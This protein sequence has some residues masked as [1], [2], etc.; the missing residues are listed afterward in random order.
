VLSY[1]SANTYA[2]Q[3][4]V[5][6]QVSNLVASAPAT[7]D[8]LNELAAAL[9]N[10]PSF[11]TTI[12]TALGNRLRVD[13][14]TQGLSATLQGYGRTNLGLGTAATSNTGDFVAYRTFGTAANSATG[15]FVAYRTFGTAANNNTEDFALASH[16]H[17]I[18]NVTGLQT[19]LDGKQASGSY[20]ASSHSHIISDVTGLQT[21]LDGK[22]AS[23]SGTG[24]VKISGTTISYDN[25]TYLTGI[26]SGQV[27]TALG[28][29]PYNSTN[30]A[31]YITGVTN[32]S[33]TAGSTSILTASGALTT[34]Q[35]SGTIIYS[36]ALTNPQ[37]GLFS[38]S[39]NSNSILTFNRHSGD[40]YSQLGFNSSGGIFYRSF[41]ATAIN[42]SQAW[43]TIWTSTSLT[44]LN[45]LTNGPGYI[46]GVTNISGTAGSISGFNNPT[47]A[48]TANTI[49]YRDSSGDLYARYFL[50]G[51][52]NTSDNVETGTI[53][54]IMAKFGD[55]YHRSATAAK[56]QAF[57]GLGSLA[58]S[59][60]T[61][62]TNN[63]QLTNGAGYI[64]GISSGNVT[65]ALGYTPYNN[66]N[67]SGYIGIN[68]QTYFGINNTSNSTG[69]G[70][71]LYGAYGGG[72]M[73]YGIMFAGTP[74]FGTHG[75]VTGDWATYFTMNADNARGWI[76]RKAG[77]A[78]VASISGGGNA[79]FTG[80]VSASNLSGT[81]TGDQTNIS[82]NAATATSAGTVTGSSTIGGYLTLSTNWGVSPYTSAFTII[83]THPSMTFR[84]SNADTHY[85]IHMD[86]AGD[87]QYYFGPGY[88]S[89]NWT[90]R[91]T[92]TKG[93]N[94]SALTGNISAS[95]TISA[96]NFSGSHSG[97]SSGTNTGDQTNISGNAAT[98]TTAT[99]SS[100]L[101]GLS[102]AQLWNNSGQNHSTYQ[103]FAAIPNFGVW[104]MQN[105]S[106]GDSPQGSSQYYVQTQGLGNDY[107]YGTYGLMTA[108]ARD[109]A[110][111]YTYYRTQ[112]GTTWGGWTKAAAGYADSAG[113]AGS[114]TYATNS[115]RLYASDGGYVYGGAAPYYMYMTYDGTRWF[116]QVN[117]AT[118]SA[119]RVSYADSAGSA[120]DSSKLPLGGGTMSGPIR[121]NSH[122]TGFL[123]GSYNNVGGNSVY[124]NPIYTIGSSYNPSDSS[125]N[126][127]YGIGYSHGNFWGGGKTPSWGLYV[128]EGGTIN[129]TIGGG[130]IT[131]WAQ[132]DI[133]AFS[134]ARVKDNVEVVTNAIEKIQAIRGVTFTRKDA[135]LED[136][137]KRHAGVIAQ[138]VL[139]VMP[140]VVTGTEKDMYSV[141]YGNMAAL[142]IEA[143]KEQQ[144]QIQELKNK[145]DSLIQN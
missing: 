104:F 23:L 65:T 68:N 94:F 60:A 45:Q 55:N 138:E 102:K 50:G 85:L 119:V 103:T 73:S 8:T 52:V 86:S 140:E 2:T 92:F 109:H 125:L 25:S 44:N 40:Y 90:Q 20:A 62:P 47:T 5:N 91:Y 121:R 57:L 39:D 118:P 132:N 143:I 83:G 98:A 48:A 136:Q 107:A 141:A 10:D 63:N 15:D 114:A 76:F 12:S 69:N 133:V 101:N 28:Y 38:T 13:I 130:A 71:S 134:D 9:G 30:P 112:E 131:I 128:C 95:G 53:T 11:A 142:F 24:F 74:T 42:T 113:S 105:S 124:T 27:T 126:S 14:N 51:Y 46:T 127:M 129:A 37:T 84:G 72:E 81:N 97:S 54:Y 82:G 31:G 66:T 93:G 139:E 36:Y 21:A 22:Q 96:S 115:T 35:G 123:E 78:N 70:I 49:A 18:A 135:K 32:I 145:L 120:T 19:A 89:N 77:T 4:Y 26:T 34:Q 16:T 122:S 61:I 110:L 6:T 144:L 106:A 41:N 75:S 29:T 56:V 17:S 64:T 79:S 80:T 117:P 58:Y 108:V 116:L 3:S 88:T 137:N 7:L 43:Q 87:I 67:P 100:Q 59:S 33:G 111:K 99:N 1:L